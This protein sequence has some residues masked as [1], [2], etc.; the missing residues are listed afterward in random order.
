MAFR[1][2]IIIML[3]MGLVASAQASAEP[4]QWRQEG[5]VKTDF[6]KTLYRAQGRNLEAEQLLK[7]GIPIIVKAHGP[8]HTQVGQ[9]L[10]SLASLYQDQGR[11]ADAEPLFKR[12][13]SILEKVH[14]RDHPHVG[15]GL[16]NIGLLY[17]DQNRYAEAEAT[18]ARSLAIRETALA[19][20]HSDVGNSLHNL[21]LLYDAQGRT[22]E[23]EPLFKFLRTTVGARTSA[24]RHGAIWRKR[25]GQRWRPLSKSTCEGPSQLSTITP[26]NYSI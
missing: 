21:A 15:T 10:S 26:R 23:A 19:S 1:V 11:Y 25:Q 13:L 3:L 16:N 17:R 18:F 12:S 22:A 7:R 24:M 4:A 9:I 20:D 2:L 6:G 5:W 14:G 8:D